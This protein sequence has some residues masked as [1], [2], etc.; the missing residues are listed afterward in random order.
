MF[1][2]CVCVL[3]SARISLCDDL[4]TSSAESYRVNVCMCK[5]M[6]DLKTSTPKRPRPDMCCSATEEV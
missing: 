4:I 5:T 2:S 3:C 6:C 1:I